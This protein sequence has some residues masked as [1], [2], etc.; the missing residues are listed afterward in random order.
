MPAG[1]LIRRS[2]RQALTS[3]VMNVGAHSPSAKP[4]TATSRIT[5]LNVSCDNKAGNSFYRYVPI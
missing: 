5:V 3:R 2:G 4:G 1:M